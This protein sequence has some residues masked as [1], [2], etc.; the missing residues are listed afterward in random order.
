MGNLN[1]R[2]YNEQQNI[3]ITDKIH[4]FENFNLLTS[5]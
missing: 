5:I 1:I 2:R 4:W 3:S